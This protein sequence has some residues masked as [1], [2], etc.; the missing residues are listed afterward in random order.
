MLSYNVEKST[1]LPF[2]AM[3]PFAKWLTSEQ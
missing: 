3:T 2:S 1:D